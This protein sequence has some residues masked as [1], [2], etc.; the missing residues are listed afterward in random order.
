LVRS[1]RLD[2]G[3]LALKISTEEVFFQIAIA[4]PCGLLLHE[5]LSNCVK[6]AFPGGR[7]GSIEVTLRRNPQR[8]YVLTVSDDGVGLPPGLDVRTTPSLGLQLVH[9]LAEQLHGTLTVER[10]TGTTITLTF[11]ASLSA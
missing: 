1:H 11:S 4:I 9:L 7:S 3:R 2:Q 10:H 6:H 8:T 5:L